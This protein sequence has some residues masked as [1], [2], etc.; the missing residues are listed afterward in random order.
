M[1]QYINVSRAVITGSKLYS[2]RIMTELYSTTGQLQDMDKMGWIRDQRDSQNS[3]RLDNFCLVS[4]DLGLDNL[5]NAQS[6]GV[7]VSTT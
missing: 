7:L 1:Q 6:Q 5:Q 2:V 4:L 3:L